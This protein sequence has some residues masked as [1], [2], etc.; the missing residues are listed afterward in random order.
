MLIRMYVAEL[1]DQSGSP[2]T[3]RNCI[4]PESVK[5]VINVVA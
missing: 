1:K 2:C 4:G 3:T 5:H